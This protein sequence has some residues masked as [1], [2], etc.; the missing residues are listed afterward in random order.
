MPLVVLEAYA[1]RGECLN[2]CH[3]F[4]SDNVSLLK[5]D[6]SFTKLTPP[7]GRGIIAEPGR[8]RTGAETADSTT[9]RNFV[10]AIVLAQGGLASMFTGEHIFRDCGWYMIQWKVWTRFERMATCLFPGKALSNC[11]TQQLS[12]LVRQ[13]MSGVD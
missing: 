7:I 6:D 11:W 10:D 13:A 5:I 12:F 1:G 2:L 3:L 8:I 9:H 4:T